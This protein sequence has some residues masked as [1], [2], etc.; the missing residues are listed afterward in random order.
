M[1]SVLVPV[2]IAFSQ[3]NDAKVEDLVL[4]IQQQAP[5]SQNIEQ[6][7][8]QLSELGIESA[9]ALTKTLPKIYD[10]HTFKKV[11]AQLCKLDYRPAISALIH[12]LDKKFV[13]STT[14]QNPV[15]EALE[16]WGYKATPAILRGIDSPNAFIH[17]TCTQMICERVWNERENPKVIEAVYKA[18]ESPILEIRKSALGGLGSICLEF[19]VWSMDDYFGPIIL[20]D[21]KAFIR[22]CE[23]AALPEMRAGNSV[24]DYVYSHR[25]GNSLHVALESS[26]QPLN[27]KVPNRE[28]LYERVADDDVYVALAAASALAAFDQ[29]VG[30]MYRALSSKHKIVRDFGEYL[31]EVTLQRY[32][33]YDFSEWLGK[34]AENEDPAYRITAASALGKTRK[35]N[36]L[37]ILKKLLSDPN[38]EVR[39]SAKEAIDLITH[40]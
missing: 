18:A 36:A 17:M 23:L 29:G 35:S 27:K 11:G 7:D 14:H 26:K 1:V 40:L 28:Q 16:R 34:L 33:M 4:R 9:P 15:R 5:K 19:H 25:Y 20:K 10:H 3:S 12:I 31:L 8:K 6:L 13:S 24:H 37:P 22:Y 21:H 38:A 30:A 2:A 39:K 32:S